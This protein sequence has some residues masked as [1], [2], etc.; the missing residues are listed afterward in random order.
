MKSWHGFVGQ[1][2]VVDTLIVSCR[3]AKQKGV[4]LQHVLLGG[5]SGYGKTHLAD[6]VAREMETVFHACYASRETAR[7][8]LVEVLMKIKKGDVLFID[9]IHALPN[10]CQEL[11]YPAISKWRVQKIDPNTG[12]VM[13]NEWA[14]CPP[15]TLVGASDQAGKL[16]RALKQRFVETFILGDYTLPEIRQIVLNYASTEGLVINAQAATRIAQAARFNPRLARDRLKALYTG[17][18]TTSAEITRPMVNR[19][20]KLRKID[21]DNLNPSD[22]Q[23]L[24]ALSAGPRSL[25]NLSIQFGSDKDAV[26]QDI[27]PYLIRKGLVEISRQG[28]RLTASGL[29]FVKERGLA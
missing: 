20:L 26:S 7:T 24:R 25:N 3:G 28:R 22:R 27:E 16:M 5:P 18:E 8:D 6:C 12:R 10:D 29:A 13:C 11:L 14:D 4:P 23:Y 15:F 19:H 17:I 21:A 2:S 9:E 1:K